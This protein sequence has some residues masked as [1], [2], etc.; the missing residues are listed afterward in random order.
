MKM[1]MP[2][3]FYIPKNA[4][5]VTCTGTDAAIYIYESQTGKP[6]A[7]GFHGRANKPDFHYSYPTVQARADAIARYL[8][9]RK[10]SAKLKAELKAERQKP[11]TLKVGD[12]LDCSWGWEQTQADFY[13]VTRVIGPHTVEIRQIAAAT[14]PGSEVSHGM[15]DRR[16]AVPNNFIGDPLVR[17]AN[18]TNSVMAHASY[19]YASL[20][21]GKPNYCSWYA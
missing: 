15:A 11:H 14:V 12:I 3:E 2:R 5:P 18:S 10:Q 16:V 9:G 19:A 17:R 1:N 8:D 20:W 21:D 4:V 7:I 6:Y 13:Q